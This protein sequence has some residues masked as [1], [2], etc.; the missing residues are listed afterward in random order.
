MRLMRFIN[1]SVRAERFASRPSST[2]LTSA[3]EQWHRTWMDR[4]KVHLAAELYDK[5]RYLTYWRIK[6]REK[7]ELVRRAKFARKYLLLCNAWRAWIQKLDE[8]RRMSKLQ[9]VETKLLSKHLTSKH[10]DYIFPPVFNNYAA[11][12]QQIAARERRHREAIQNFVLASNAVITFTI[13]DYCKR[14]NTCLTATR[15]ESPGH[16]DKPRD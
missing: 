14:S 8:Q 2:L 9:M 13:L 5:Q 15:E 10:S 12:W 3:L 4:R 1:E 6:L 16:M 7:L 11:E